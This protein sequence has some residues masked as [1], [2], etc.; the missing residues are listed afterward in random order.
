M[1]ISDFI[2]YHTGTTTDLDTNADEHMVATDA[3][4]DGESYEH[5]SNDVG[6]STGESSM[7]TSAPAIHVSQICK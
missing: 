6:E 3:D 4:W 1:T 2:N 7:S 5:H